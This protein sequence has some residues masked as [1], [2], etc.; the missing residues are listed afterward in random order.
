METATATIIT[1]ASATAVL[2]LRRH[3]ISEVVSPQHAVM[4]ELIIQPPLQFMRVIASR[5]DIPWATL[6][7]LQQLLL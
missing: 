7:N 6:R 4:G 3:L 5:L 1:P 2:F